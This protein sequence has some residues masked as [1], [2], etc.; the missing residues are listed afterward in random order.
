MSP[1]N[2]SVFGAS[3]SRSRYLRRSFGLW[4]AGWL[5]VIPARAEENFSEP[6]SCDKPIREAILAQ[7]AAIKAESPEILDAGFTPS[8]PDVYDIS[9]AADVKEGFFSLNFRVE[10][11]TS[12]DKN[13]CEV[14]K[15]EETER[16]PHP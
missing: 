16:H 11:K 3:G 14:I 13:T 1:V 5:T 10:T 6:K 2:F 8:R 9:V 15:V 4:L 12:E 7:C